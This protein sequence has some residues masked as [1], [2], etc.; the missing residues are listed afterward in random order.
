[1]SFKI[2][3]LCFLSVLFLSCLAWALV[4][5]AAFPA[6]ETYVFKTLTPPGAIQSEASGINNR[7]DIVGDFTDDSGTHG[8]PGA[9]NTYCEGINARGTIVGGYDDLYGGI[10]GFIYEKALSARSMSQARII[11]LQPMGSTTRTSS[12]GDT[13]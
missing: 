12:S 2:N 8:F 9:L 7:G 6:A 4:A 1:M 3:K 10:Y 13:R 11:G 5:P